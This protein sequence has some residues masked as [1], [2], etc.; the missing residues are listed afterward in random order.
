MKPLVLS[1]SPTWSAGCADACLS[2][3]SWGDTGGRTPGVHW[4]ARL[5]ELMIFRAG[6]DPVIDGLTEDCTWCRLL[7]PKYVPAYAW[8]LTH[9]CTRT[10]IC[11]QTHNCYHRLFSL[12]SLLLMEYMLMGKALTY[13]QLPPKLPK[14]LRVNHRATQGASITKGRWQHAFICWRKNSSHPVHGN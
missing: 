8:T 12:Y 14:L 6:K 1:P 4:P 11:T 13:Y 7:V 10:C 2:L 9:M 5:A 3:Q